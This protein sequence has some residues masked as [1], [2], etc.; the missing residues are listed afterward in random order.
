VWTT[1]IGESQARDPGLRAAGAPGWAD[2]GVRALTR[3]VDTASPVHPGMELDPRRVRPRERFERVPP[4]VRVWYH[5]P[6]VDR[7][8]HSWM[9][10]H[11]GW[12]AELLRPGG[13]EA[14]GRDG[15]PVSLAPLPCLTQSATVPREEYD[16]L[17][18]PDGDRSH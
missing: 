9:R 10:C 2:A 7:Y 5:T 18:P 8:A 1:S 17:W 13:G 12:D 4:W 15:A 3:A 16:D 14:G 6:S 11:G